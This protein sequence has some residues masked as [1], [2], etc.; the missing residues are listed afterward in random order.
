[1]Q[2]DPIPKPK[3]ERISVKL[4]MPGITLGIPTGALAF[5]QLL[6]K[7]ICRALDDK[8]ILTELPESKYESL[9]LKGPQKCFVVGYGQV[10][11]GVFAVT[12]RMDGLVTIR[13]ALQSVSLLAW[14]EIAWLDSRELVWRYWHPAGSTAR[15]EE[16]E[17]FM[18]HLK[19]LIL[20]MI[21]IRTEPE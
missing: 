8:G 6:E 13:D 1:M 18:L 3:P 21:K 5:C 7:A 15:I 16:N 4:T 14:S 2:T 19:D 9:R 17:P 20:A 11:M 10:V 12:N